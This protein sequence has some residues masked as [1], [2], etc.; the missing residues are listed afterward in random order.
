MKILQNTTVKTVTNKNSS[1][2]ARIPCSKQ[3]HKGNT[4]C[5]KPEIQNKHN[6]T[7]ALSRAEQIDQLKY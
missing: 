5:R 3:P 6:Y 1:S 4:K 2:T 7:S